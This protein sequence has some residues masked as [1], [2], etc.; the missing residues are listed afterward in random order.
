MKAVLSFTLVLALMLPAH[1]VAQERSD[2]PAIQE[3]EAPQIADV[4]AALDGHSRVSVRLHRGETVTGTVTHRTADG[5]YIA[6]PPSGPRFVRYSEV[7]AILNPDSGVVEAR[8]EPQPSE[9]HSTRRAAIIAAA[10]GVWIL[11]AVVT[12]GNGI[13]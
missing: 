3:A 10:V 8:V 5:L 1:P 4:R 13:G 9:S 6:H 12:R 7:V 11:I 2:V